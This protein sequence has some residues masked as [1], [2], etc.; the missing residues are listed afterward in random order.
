M[1][2]QREL[3]LNRP[4]TSKTKRRLR[5]L[6]QAVMQP[7]N[8]IRQARRLKKISLRVAEISFALI[9]DF[10]HQVRGVA[11]IARQTVRSVGRVFEEFL[12]LAADMT[13][14]TVRRVFLRVGAKVKD[15]KLLQCG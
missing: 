1:N 12:L 7:A 3:G 2:G 6:Q 10:F 13:Q 11:L 14:Q 8:L 5:L 15:G 9:F 4:V